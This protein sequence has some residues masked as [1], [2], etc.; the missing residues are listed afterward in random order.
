MSHIWE[1]EEK[2]KGCCT[3]KKLGQDPVVTRSLE[4]ASLKVARDRTG[5]RGGPP[6]PSQALKAFL[7]LEMLSAS[8]INCLVMRMLV[9]VQ[10]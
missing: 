1:T 8:I 2:E 9:S 7:I 3:R 4:N 10:P 6:T 5:R